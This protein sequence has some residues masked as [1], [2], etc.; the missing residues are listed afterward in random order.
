[1]KIFAFVDVHAQVRCI[2][3]ILRE[4]R[5]ADFLVCAGDLSNFCTGLEKMTKML[6]LANKPMIMVHGNHEESS[7]IDKLALKF[8]FVVN[9]HRR[10]Y[11][12]GNVAFVGYGGGGFAFEDK[13]ME[14]FFENIKS[15]IQS[16]DNV[17]LVTHA[18]A[19]GKKVDYVPRLGH[20][21]CISV[22]RGIKL[23]KP[24]YVIAGHLHETSGKTDKLGKTFLLNPGC[25][26]RM[27]EI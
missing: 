20:R 25:A 7:D 23:L 9:V 13:G 26:G 22:N 10:L 11:R 8:P 4:S 5:G 17:V 16:F 21:G 2:K 6:A 3:K 24:A 14:R 19:Y 12:V 15:K 1:M 27:L 18:P